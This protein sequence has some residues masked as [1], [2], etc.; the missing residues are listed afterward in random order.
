MASPTRLRAAHEA[1]DQWQSVANHPNI[2]TLRGTFVSNEIQYVSSLFL[3]YDYFSAA[4][5][6]K[7]LNCRI[8]KII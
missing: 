6:Q 2:V 1:V 8:N 5:N 4:V 7:T 3:V